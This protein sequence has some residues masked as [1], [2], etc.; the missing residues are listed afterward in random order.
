[1]LGLLAWDTM[2]VSVVS[3]TESR[4][5][6]E[7]ILTALF[8]VGKPAHYSGTVPSAEDPGLNKGLGKGLPVSLSPSLLPSFFTLLL[9]W[10]L[11]CDQVLRV[12]FH[13]LGTKT[14]LFPW[15]YFCQSLT[16]PE[17]KLRK[18]RG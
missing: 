13:E 8:K 18:T 1:M 10:P 7:M 9:S 2:M 12:S 5:A 3:L 16:S 4:L 11:R 17:K 6:W 14:H 15:S